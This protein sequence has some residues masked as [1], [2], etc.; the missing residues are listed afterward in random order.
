VRP[1]PFPVLLVL[2]WTLACGCEEKI[3]PT[4][5]PGLD[6]KTLPQQESWNSSVVLSDSGRTKAVIYAGRI[7]EFESPRETL[8]DQNITVHFYG[9][10]GNETSVL[11]AREG[12]VDEM[13]N[14]LEASGD[15]V[16]VSNDSTRLHTEKLYW[17]N[18]RQLVHTPDY[19][20]I[21]SPK[22]RVEG[23]GLESDQQLRNYRIFR[24]TGESRAD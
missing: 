9:E 1:S 7:R 2:L 11:T 24:V 21:V 20:L 10:D 5:L 15:V 13:T 16:V 18:K 4:V 12:K 14:N 19:V 3:K 8:L 6:S 17:D 22:E 23:K